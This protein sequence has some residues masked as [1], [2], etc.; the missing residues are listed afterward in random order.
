MFPNAELAFSPHK[1]LRRQPQFD[2][3]N[4]SYT[5]ETQICRDLLKDDLESQVIPMVGFPSTWRIIPQVHLRLEYLQPLSDA[6]LPS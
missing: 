4:P 5:F 1:I 6:D 2:A 3:N